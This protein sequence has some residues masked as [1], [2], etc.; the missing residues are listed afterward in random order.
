MTKR[1]R[2]IFDEMLAGPAIGCDLVRSPPH[3]D[4]PAITKVKA[5]IARAERW[6]RE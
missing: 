2:E 1:E 3:Q 4:A 5:A 6:L